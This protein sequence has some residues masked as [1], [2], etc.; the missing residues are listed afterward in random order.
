LGEI[1]VSR[2][3]V[4]EVTISYALVGMCMKLWGRKQG[5]FHL[6]SCAYYFQ[7]IVKILEDYSE[8]LTNKAYRHQLAKEKKLTENVE[9]NDAVNATQSVAA[10]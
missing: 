5:Y 10:K 8:R 4:T 1:S 9:K 6:Y 7:R 2:P 3:L